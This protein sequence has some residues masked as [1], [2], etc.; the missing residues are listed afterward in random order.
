MRPN[1]LPSIGPMRAERI[2]N[3][4]ARIGGDAIATDRDFAEVSVRVGDATVFYNVDSGA[5][6]EHLPQVIAERRANAS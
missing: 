5:V 4:L 1:Q 3:R 2:A 6:V